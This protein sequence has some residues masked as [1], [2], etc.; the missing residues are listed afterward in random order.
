MD[1]LFKVFDVNFEGYEVIFN[2]VLNKI[3]KYGNDD[4]YVDEIM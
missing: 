3:F 4:D 2:L 1:I